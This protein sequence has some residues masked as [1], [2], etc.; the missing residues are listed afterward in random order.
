MPS[1]TLLNSLKKLN[2]SRSNLLFWVILRKIL[3]VS[4]H[5]QQQN[6]RSR[7]SSTKKNAS[8]MKP[9][10]SSS[11]THSLQLPKMLKPRKLKSENWRLPVSS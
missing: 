1:K 11:R 6:C 9:A 8:S 4:S 10:N 2:N 3:N 5:L 7:R